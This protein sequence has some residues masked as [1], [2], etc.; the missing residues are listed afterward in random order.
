MK[1]IESIVTVKERGYIV[2]RDEMV[3]TKPADGAMVDPPITLT[4]PTS[5]D[6]L[7]F[8]PANAWVRVR[9][10]DGAGIGWIKA[11]AV[12]KLKSGPN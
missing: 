6:I 11:D 12:R 7:E 2:M 10:G 8:D 9:W 4:A 5:V 3:H 1:P